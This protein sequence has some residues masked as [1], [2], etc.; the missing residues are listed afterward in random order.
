MMIMVPTSRPVSRSHG[1]HVTSG[2]FMIP[3]HHFADF[4][5]MV[6]GY[7]DFEAV[8]VEG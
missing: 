8:D 2:G 7:D 6:C 4:S 3:T 5:K 1:H